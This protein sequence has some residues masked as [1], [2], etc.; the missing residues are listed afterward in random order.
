MRENFYLIAEIKAKISPKILVLD[1]NDLKGQSENEIKNYYG[2]DQI[3]G[4]DLVP[5][6]PFKIVLEKNLKSENISL[7]IQRSMKGNAWTVI[8][9]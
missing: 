8:F 6:E 2:N 7:M 3:S 1:W 9:L 4:F 5:Q